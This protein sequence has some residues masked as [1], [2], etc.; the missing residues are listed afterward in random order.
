VAFISISTKAS[1][2]F[3]KTEQLHRRIVL[4]QRKELAHEH[5]QAAIAGH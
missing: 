2:T 4:P 5:R 1:E 3:L